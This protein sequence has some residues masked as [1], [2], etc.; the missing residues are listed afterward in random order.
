MIMNPSFYEGSGMNTKHYDLFSRMLQDRV[1]F[2]FHEIT[3]DLA[4]SVIAQLLYLE[5]V[6]P[7]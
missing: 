2:V 5:S 6:D 4:G 7:E 1:I 3:E